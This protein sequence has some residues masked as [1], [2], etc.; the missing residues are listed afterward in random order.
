VQGEELSDAGLEHRLEV[1]RDDIASVR[2]GVRPLRGL[3]EGEALFAVERFALSANNVTYGALMGE[4][5]GYWDLFPAAPG[6]GLIPVWGYLR[7]LDSRAAGVQEGG[8]AY[9]F[10]PPAS[11]V[12]LRPAR[13]ST[14]GFA[15]AA[16]HRRALDTVY[17]AY[18]WL[19]T[20][21]AYDPALADEML[22][23]RPLFWL[24]FMLD[25]HLAGE[26][27]A[28]GAEVLITSASSKASIGTAF[29]LARRGVP[30][31]GLTSPANVDFV[32]SLGLYDEVLSYPDLDRGPRAPAPSVLLDI[33][34]SGAI[35]AALERHLGERLRLA[36]VAGGT[37]VDEDG[38]N[39]DPAGGGARF[40]FVPERMRARARELGWNALNAR[41]C[42]ALRSFVADSARWLRVESAEGFEEVHAAYRRTLENETPPRIAQVLS[43]APDG[44]HGEAA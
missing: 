34:G 4:R 41:Y 20:D 40:L 32:T 27:A 26:R 17:N 42:E 28:D 12:V 37:H 13:P 14:A 19:E 22:V 38:A 6:W 11:H 9:G 39:P 10:C 29:L 25:D 21:P 5:L 33:A 15:D 2:H 24:S 43:L 30:T 18:S 31:V 1:R 36:I 3:D 8:R 35:R 23:V 16:D 7:A 44:A